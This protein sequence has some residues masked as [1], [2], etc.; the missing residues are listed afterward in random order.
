MPIHKRSINSQ[1]N[2]SD[3]QNL[4]TNYNTSNYNNYSHKEDFR[5]NYNLTNITLEDLDMAVYNEFNKRFHIGEKDMP[6]LL[7]DA[8]VPA[9][10]NDNYEQFDL[11]KGFLNLPFLT[12]F[13][14]KTTR[15]RKTNPANKMVAYAIPKKKENG[16]VFEEYITEAPIEFELEYEIKFITNFRQSTNEMEQQMAY[17]FRNKRNMILF[18]GERFVISPVSQDTLGEVEIINRE[19]IDQRTLYMTTYNLKMWAYTRNI[20]TMQKRER[21][22]RFLL[23]ITVKDSVNTESSSDVINVERYDLENTQLPIHPTNSPVNYSTAKFSD[24]NSKQ[25]S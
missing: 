8:E 21:P 4:R 17:Y 5:T 7:L 24:T 23:D 11:D 16:I 6:I 18:N 14:T 13:R 10:M 3:Y 25:S 15:L 1:F 19:T 12:L 20:A 9:L 2:Y 22:N